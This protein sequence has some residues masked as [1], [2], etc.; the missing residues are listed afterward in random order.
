M[1][2]LVFS[3]FDTKAAAYMQPFFSLTAGTAV[4][5]FSDALSDSSHQFCRYPEDYSLV[6]IG[7]FD[8]ATGKLAFVSPDTITTASAEVAARAVRDP[9]SPNLVDLMKAKA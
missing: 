6:H 7:S 9:G 3:V 1:K 2:H 4:R 5:S 8:D